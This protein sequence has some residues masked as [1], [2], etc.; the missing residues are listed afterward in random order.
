MKISATVWEF[1]KCNT[2]TQSEQMLLKNST[3]VF[4]QDRVATSLHFIKK[5]KK[6]EYLQSTIEQSTIKW[7]TCTYELD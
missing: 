6:K 2:E 1:S 4:A 5:K 3:D 7:G